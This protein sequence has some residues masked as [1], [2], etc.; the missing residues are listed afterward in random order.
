[1]KQKFL[2]EDLRG[3][4]EEARKLGEMRDV[5]GATWQEDIGMATEMLHHTD[6]APAALFDSVPGYPKG[7]RVLTNFFGKR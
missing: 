3:W 4:I 6:P 2:Y 5:E 1:M 7:F